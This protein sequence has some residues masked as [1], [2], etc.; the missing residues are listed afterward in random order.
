MSMAMR[1]LGY[2]PCGERILWA[3]KMLETVVDIND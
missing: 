2:G 1:R 3:R